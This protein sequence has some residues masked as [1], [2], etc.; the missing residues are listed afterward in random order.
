VSPVTN[1]KP[2]PRAERV[3]VQIKEVLATELERLRDPGLGYVTITDVRLS[4]DLR[5][6]T[7]FYTVY[8]DETARAATA[9][10]LER[11]VPHLRTA[12][13]RKVR[14]RYAPA[15]GF[16]ADPVPERTSRLDQIIAELHRREEDE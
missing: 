1:P 13:A 11:A 16:E 6:A 8:G 15:I 12:V 3:R 10:A 4:P 2:Y 9:E 5:N 14:M 7:A